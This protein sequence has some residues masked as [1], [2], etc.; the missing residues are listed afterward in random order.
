MSEPISPPVAERLRS[1][2]V[3]EPTQD[4]V[5][6][7][8]REQLIGPH[9]V[10]ELGRLRLHLPADDPAVAGLARTGQRVLI[11]ITDVAAVPMRDRVRA[12]AS[13][14]GILDVARG[15]TEITALLSLAVAEWTEDG[16]PTAV[17]A[18]EF[19]AADPD[20][21]ASRETALLC[22][23]VDAHADLVGWLTRLVPA[24]RL[25]GVCRVAPLRL[26]RYGIVLRCEFP[27]FDR[28][29]RLRFS[30]PVR[31][32]EDAPGRMLELLA[33]ARACRRRVA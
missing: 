29:V 25:H 23:L 15:E 32:P 8:S 31:V 4:V 13:L 28:D 20:P 27:G 24:G 33:R 17:G 12:R 10:D 6:D 5:F 26:D 19:A 16:E 21:L 14:A 1:L 9:D 3:A 22:H 11:E 7:R 30:A 2:L 18:A